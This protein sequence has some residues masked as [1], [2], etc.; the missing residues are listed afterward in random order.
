MKTAHKGGKWPKTDLQYVK[1]LKKLLSV[2][3][4]VAE[5][6]TLEIILYMSINE[7]SSSKTLSSIL[8]ILFLIEAL[9][10]SL[11]VN[12][13][14]KAFFLYFKSWL[15][16][17]KIVWGTTWHVSITDSGSEMVK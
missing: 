3:V 11:K 15:F 12:G 4:F 16:Y 17:V 1:F 6:C 2:H 7:S 13:I 14:E 5:N 10:S 9:G 8:W